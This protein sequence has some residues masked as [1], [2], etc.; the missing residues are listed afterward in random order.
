[1]GT[2]HTETPRFMNDNDRQIEHHPWEPFLP[3]NGKLLFLGSFPPPQRRWSMPFYYPNIT[4]D[5]WKIIG[6]IFF[7]DEH[8]FILK[9]KKGFDLPAIKTFLNERGIAMYDAATTVRRARNNASDLHLDILERSDI[10]G[11]MSQMPL[12]K[13]IAV[14]G[15]KSAQ[16]LLA[17]YEKKTPDIGK[18]VNITIAG[19]ETTVFRMPSTSRAYPLPLD[20]KA[21]FYRALFNETGIDI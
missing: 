13:T 11:L 15:E 10:A 17:P 6:L 4:N 8:H 9:E 2:A 19:R 20:K 21:A 7:N 12:C 1:M 14:T 3:S 16:T 5:F 18:S